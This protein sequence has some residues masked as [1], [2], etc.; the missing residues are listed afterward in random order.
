VK[1][2]P[3]SNA[4]AGWAC[5]TPSAAAEETGEWKKQRTVPQ[6]WRCHQASRRAAKFLK[7]LALFRPAQPTGPKPFSNFSNKPSSQL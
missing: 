7:L 3:G 5:T 6:P 2:K 1:K 4:G